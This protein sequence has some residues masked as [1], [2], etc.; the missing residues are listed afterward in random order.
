MRSKSYRIDIIPIPWK[1]PARRDT[2]C[3]DTRSRD[4]IAFGLQLNEQHNN[5]PYFTNPVH[6]EVAFY[7]PIYKSVKKRAHYSYHFNAPYL[8]NLYKFLISAMKD[9]IM[10]D[11]R[12]ICSLSLKKVYDEKPRTELTITEVL[13][14]EEKR[15]IQSNFKSI[16]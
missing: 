9:V 3:Y 12:I 7:M 6:L 2:R 1:Q 10:A 5:E 4:V 16:K 8:D 14:G 13:K 15:A 11:D